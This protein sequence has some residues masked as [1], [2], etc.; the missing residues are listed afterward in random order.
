MFAMIVE[1]I[2]SKGIKICTQL[3]SFQHELLNTPANP[4]DLTSLT[5]MHPPWHSTTATTFIRFL[6]LYIVE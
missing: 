5:D 6:L 1:D 2:D 3:E 4:R